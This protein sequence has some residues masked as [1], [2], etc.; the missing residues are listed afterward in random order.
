[1]RAVTASNKPIQTR[2]YTEYSDEPFI[3][4]LRVGKCKCDI[5]AHNQSDS[6]ANLFELRLLSRVD[7]TCLEKKIQL[8]H[9]IHTSYW[10]WMKSLKSLRS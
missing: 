6:V 1:M 7:F 4:V 2:H 10:R 5:S 3:F 9:S 8:N